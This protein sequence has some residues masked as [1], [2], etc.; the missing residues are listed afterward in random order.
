MGVQHWTVG[1]VRIH[2]VLQAVIPIPASRLFANQPARL[3]AHLVPDYVDAAG[4]IL[5][6][7]QSYLIES[8]A[9]RVLV[10]TCFA[11]SFLQ[12]RGIP[13]RHEESLAATGTAP[14]DITAVVCTHLHRDHA[15]RNTVERDGQWV[16]T[17]PNADYLLTEAEHQHW[18]ECTGEDRAPAE[19]VVPLAQHDKLRLV[20]PDHQVTDNVRLVP[21]AGH[22]PGHVAVRVESDGAVA[23]IGGDTVHHPIQIGDPEIA[24]LPDA[25]PGAARASREKLLRRIVDERAL[26]LGSHFTAPSAGFVVGGEG[27]MTW[28]PLIDREGTR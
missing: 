2:A 14:E 24:A 11:G 3:P 9:A 18:C 7:I 17:Y 8:A 20:D 21:A 22:T 27:G 15:G 23:Y 25:D 13:D 5:M 28:Q 6:A 1:E 19:C 12:P 26:L 10:D 4:N 16:P